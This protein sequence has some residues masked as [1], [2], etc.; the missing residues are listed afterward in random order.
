[1]LWI[2]IPKAKTASDKLKMKGENINV[3]NIVEQ[4]NAE[5]ESDKKKIKLGET[6]ENSTHELG[7]IFSKLIGFIIALISGIILTGMILS[8]TVVIPYNDLNINLMQESLSNMINLPLGWITAL[9]L[10]LIGFP[11]ALLFILGL[12]LLFPNTKS[13]GKNVFITGGTIWII[14]FLFLMIKTT[15]QI[16]RYEHKTKIL[17][18]KIV[19]NSNKDTLFVKNNSFITDTLDNFITDNRIYFNYYPSNDSLFHI[20]IYQY[21]TGITKKEAINELKKIRYVYQIDSLKNQVVFGEKMSY[22]DE[23]FIINRKI[24]IKIYIPDGKFVQLSPHISRFSKAGNCKYPSL[25]QN[26]QHK[27]NCIEKYKKNDIADEKIIINGKKI[28]IQ[29]GDNGVD[30]AA[31]NKN[32][33]AKISLNE[34]GIHINSSKKD[35]KID[36]SIDEKGIIIKNENH[37]K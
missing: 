27:I 22:P 10:F 2:V 4:V 29:A 35:K 32:K 36:I 8:L 23:N 9:G 21:A 19:W 3:D 15:S 7:Q 34:K 17:D 25:I 18:K 24:K 14:T 33:N 1:L 20:K 13:L 16:Y 31:G 6:V 11:I 28:N 37:E 12:K 5:E 26:N 30:I